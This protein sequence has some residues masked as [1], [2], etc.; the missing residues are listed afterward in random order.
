MK[1]DL[2]SDEDGPVVEGEV[3]PS[4]SR[5]EARHGSQRWSREEELKRRCEIG[6]LK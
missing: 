2:P 1:F 6:G 4:E 3:D 5:E